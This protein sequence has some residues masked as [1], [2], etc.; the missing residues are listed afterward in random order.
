MNSPSRKFILLTAVLLLAGG[1]I[2]PTPTKNMDI[3]SARLLKGDVFKLD[4]AQYFSP[5]NLSVTGSPEVK[6]ES[7]ISPPYGEVMIPKFTFKK[8]DQSS[9]TISMNDC[10]YGSFTEYQNWA[11]CGMKKDV[12]YWEFQRNRFTNVI[13]QDSLMVKYMGKDEA[14]VTSNNI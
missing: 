9:V 12:T 4:M 1:I 7:M 2:C 14:T 10:L 5:Q 3:P 6:V 8:A 11:I 13:E